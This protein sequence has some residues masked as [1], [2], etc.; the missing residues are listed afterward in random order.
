MSE[1]TQPKVHK[2]PFFFADAVVLGVAWLIFWQ[3]KTPMT[4]WQTFFCA[5]SVAL[6]ATFGVM[7]FLL[8]YRAAMKLAEADRLTNAVLQIE[9]LEIIGRQIANATAGWQTAQEHADKAVEAAREIA[10]GITKEARAFSEF[11]QKANDTEKNHLRLEVDKL[12]RAENE[13][14]QVLVRLLD[15]TYAL[16][17]AAVG[18]GQTNLV[19]QLGQFQNACRDVARRVGLVP[20]VAIPGESYDP[21]VHQLSDTKV[22]PAAAARVA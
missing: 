14:L 9:N 3:S 12:R 17:Q 8:E 15:H 22:V 1:R 11:L 10:D 7:P 4:A 20:F 19:K 13:W 5:A 18:S 2:L 21:K 6:G 16:Y